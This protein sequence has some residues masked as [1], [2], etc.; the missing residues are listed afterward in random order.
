MGLMGT[1]L[2]SDS[3][4]LALSNLQYSFAQDFQ[5]DTIGW[6]NQ[7]L[8]TA[9]VNIALG[10]IIPMSLRMNVPEF[11]QPGSYIGTIAL[12]AVKG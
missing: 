4:T 1:D 2:A 5:S 8:S 9:D 11:A 12:L 7:S 10:V 6:F 3:G